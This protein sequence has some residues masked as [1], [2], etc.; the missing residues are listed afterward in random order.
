ME[1]FRDRFYGYGDVFDL[2]KVEKRRDV[3]WDVFLG[4]EMV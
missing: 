2:G 4:E 3:V 1:S